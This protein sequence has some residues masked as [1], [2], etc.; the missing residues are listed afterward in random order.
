MHVLADGPVGRCPCP[1]KSP[2]DRGVLWHEVTG[3]PD[4]LGVARIVN[5]SQGRQ[6]QPA[7]DGRRSE[8]RSFRRAV[9]AFHR[10]CGRRFP[11]RESSEPYAVLIGEILLQ[12]T[13]AEHTPA[14]YRRFLSLWPTPEALARAPTERIED[15]IA[16]LGLRKR[17]ALLR[18][19]GGELTRL[20]RVP[21]SPE[22]LAALPGVGPYT[23]HAVPIF[24]RNRNLPLVDWV[25]ARVLRRYFGVTGTQRPNSDEELWAL[26]ERVVE[27][28]R[29]REVWLGTLDLAAAVCKS[30]PTCGECPLKAACK[31]TQAEVR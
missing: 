2:A 21:L 9:L 26:A 23:A 25:I 5:D 22:A 12:R 8:I 29:A 17:A 7:A 19:L 16:P 30:K 3:R 15:V 31:F 6:K 18:K 4:V 14:A 28:G 11:W 10:R 24:A 1:V 20:G 13:R 27:P